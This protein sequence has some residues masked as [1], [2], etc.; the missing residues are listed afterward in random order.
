MR[1]IVMLLLAGGCAGSGDD[2]T[3]SELSTEM[4][5]AQVPSDPCAAPP[6]EAPVV[7]AVE[8]VREEVDGYP[9]WQHV[10]NDEPAALYW[11]FHGS[12]GTYDQIYGLEVAYLLNMLTPQGYAA[13]ATN[14]TRDESEWDKSSTDPS[15]NA[16]LARLIAIRDHLI[17]TTA[18]TEETPI[19]LTGFSDG[20]SMATWLSAVF[21]ELGWDVRVVSVH[22]SP[23]SD[24]PG[25]I[26]AP[27]FW[28]VSENDKSTVRDGA[29]RLA[30]IQ[31][32]DLGWP[33]RYLEAP[34]LALDRERFNRVPEISE[35]AGLA[36]GLFDELVRLEL[37]DGDGARIVDDDLSD[38]ENMDSLFRYVTANVDS[39]LA[40]EAGGQ[41]RII[42]ATHRFN[43]Y[44]AEEEC[45]FFERF[46]EAR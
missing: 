2:G 14:N 3:G 24:Y 26:E 30:D 19:V 6:L 35:T 9:I 18:V 22:N 15:E 31:E 39:R 7:L 28:A 43:G 45:R 40:D 13:V 25:E 44:H 23:A 27:T 1:V 32:K 20:G 21:V 33:S 34:E 37:I 11:F 36:S 10:P 29:K 46:I 8:G 42:W 12:N 17:A 5:G 41:L 4:S 16:E 38:P